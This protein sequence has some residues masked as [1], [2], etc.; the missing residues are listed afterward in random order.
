MV[1]GVTYISTA[2]PANKCQPE[3]FR[4][5]S[6]SVYNTAPLAQ[7]KS[8]RSAGWG[9]FTRCLEL[10]YVDAGPLCWLLLIS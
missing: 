1:N 5:V 9:E 10:K 3:M 6:V 8:V 4:R 7:H 2:R